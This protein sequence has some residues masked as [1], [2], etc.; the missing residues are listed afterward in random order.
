MNKIEE[1][2]NTL[3]NEGLQ[4]AAGTHLENDNGRDVIILC[5]DDAESSDEYFMYETYSV[6]EMLEYLRKE[7]LTEII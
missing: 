2:Y 6:S 1:V 4:L 3:E 7:N 5:N